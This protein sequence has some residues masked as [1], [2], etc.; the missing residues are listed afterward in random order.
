GIGDHDWYAILRLDPRADDATIRTQYKKM[1]L[2]LHPDKN[3]MN[4]AE[5]A[6]KLVNEAWTLLSDKNKKMI[7]DSIR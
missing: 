5:E 6:F 7:Y 2:V 4:G 3:R 1:A